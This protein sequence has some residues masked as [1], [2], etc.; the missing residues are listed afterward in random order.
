MEVN[1]VNGL[2]HHLQA[3]SRASMFFSKLFNFP[4]FIFVFDM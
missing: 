3:D 1:E 2:Q 4:K